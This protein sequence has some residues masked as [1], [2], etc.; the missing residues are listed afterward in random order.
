MSKIRQWLSDPQVHLIFSGLAQAISVFYPPAAPFIP[1][2]QAIAGTLTVT[3]FALPENGSMHAADWAK[4]AAALPKPVD[5]Q[6]RT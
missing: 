1:M 3:A 2:L 6:G 5:A 4:L